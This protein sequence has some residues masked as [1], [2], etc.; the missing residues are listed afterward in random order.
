[1]LVHLC[2]FEMHHPNSTYSPPA[3]CSAGM[4]TCP[5]KSKIL[6]SKYPNLSP[7]EMIYATRGADSFDFKGFNFVITSNELVER[8]KVKHHLDGIRCHNWSSQCE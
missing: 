2:T 1:M 4:S 3:Y 8:I 5:N 6:G 7:N